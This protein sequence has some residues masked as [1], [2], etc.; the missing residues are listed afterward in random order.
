MESNYGEM[1]CDS[2]DSSLVFFYNV[3]L[4]TGERIFFLGNLSF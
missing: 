4:L 1:H 3:K 2:V